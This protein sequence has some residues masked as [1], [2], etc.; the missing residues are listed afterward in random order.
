MVILLPLLYWRLPESP[1]WLEAHG[2]HQEAERV[3]AL[4]ER[5]CQAAL[6]EPLPAPN[7]VLDQVISA[8]GGSWTELFTSPQYRGRTWLLIFV[9]LLAYAGLIYG[10]VRL[11]RFTWW[12]TAAT[13]ISCS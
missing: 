5:R 9:W 12:I 11:R 6:A 1:R 13:R 10:W 3:M 7:P 2:R 8:Q 4:L